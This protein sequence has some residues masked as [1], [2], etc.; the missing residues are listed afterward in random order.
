[1]NDPRRRGGNR[2]A[3]QDPAYSPSPA[4]LT[5]LGFASLRA[6]ACFVRGY[7]R[8]GPWTRSA[9]REAVLRDGDH[10]LDQSGLLVGSK[11]ISSGW[12]G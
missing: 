1:M 2:P 12:V 7:E 8:D 3:V 5:P 4:F 11:L 6:F 9:L 10:V